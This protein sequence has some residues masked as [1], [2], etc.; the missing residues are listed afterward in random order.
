MAA[1]TSKTL[2]SSEQFL[3]MAV[4]S[5]LASINDMLPVAGIK[6]DTSAS[7]PKEALDRA[8]VETQERADVS[9]ALKTLSGTALAQCLRLLRESNR[10]RRDIN[11][12]N[13]SHKQIMLGVY[14]TMYQRKLKLEKQLETDTYA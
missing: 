14:R 6:N 12:M 8:A 3:K 4:Q 1:K 10:A 11:I 2:A 5:E 7:I 9:N 13:A